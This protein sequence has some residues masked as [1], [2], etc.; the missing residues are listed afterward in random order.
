[1]VYKQA[2]NENSREVPQSDW[3]QRLNTLGRH[4]GPESIVALSVDALLQAAADKTGL[5][6]FGDDEFREGL[7]AL[8][9]SLNNEASLT[10]TGRLIARTEVSRILQSRLAIIDTEK[11]HPEI[12]DEEIIEPLF[13]VG[14]GRTGSS[15]LY[16]YFMQDPVHRAP[17]AWEKKLPAPPLLPDDESE[18]QHRIDWI[19]AET[20]LMYE[21]DS[22][23][24]SKHE[25]H[26]RLPEECSQ[27]MAHEFQSGHFFSRNNVP[28]YALWNAMA[29]A[30]PAYAMHKRILKILQWR[31]KRQNKPRWILK[32]GGHMGKMPE[33]FET[34][35]DAKVIHTHRDPSVV[36]QSMTSLIASLRLMRSDNFD[37]PTS[38]EM[39]NAGMARGLE[40]MI[41]ERKEGV[42]PEAQIADIHFDTL[43]SDTIGE[44]A[45]AYRK[46]N[47][48]FTDD[49]EA[50]IE[51]YMQARPR[52]KHGKHSYAYADAIDINKEQQ[53]FA[54]Y[55]N[56]YAIKKEN[57]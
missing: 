31:D 20:A 53:R 17:L 27:L 44:I 43:M 57:L 22:S 39:L 34:Y 1:M 52:T 51:R 37:A 28:G 30:R 29:D 41:A 54:D 26:A 45:N 11:R 42:I 13:I 16:E 55:M 18:A 56:H 49:A 10:L 6:D 8:V 32:Y 15:I 7:H 48:P 14:M 4:I 19:E 24:M 25:A 3:A 33:L 35:P 36:V 21:I 47:M 38:A 5:S 12:A 23:L 40:K 2:D 46:L 50:A 9:E